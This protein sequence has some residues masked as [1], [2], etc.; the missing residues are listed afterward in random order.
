MSETLLR[1]QELA[2]E[3]RRGGSTVRAV[4][5]IDF[6][7]A[8]G[9]TL[10]LVGESGCGKSTVAKSV[11]R[12]LRPTRGRIEFD[13]H[14]L[15]PLSERQLR[16]HRPRLQMVFQDPQASLNPRMTVRDAIIEPLIIHR[17][18]DRTAR[19]ARVREM[20][21]RVG[22]ARRME[23]RFPFQ[24]SGGQQQRVALARALALNPDLVVADE[25]TSAL[26]V[27]IQ[28]QI[29]E[30]L[31]ELQRDLGIAYLLISHNL[32]AVRQLAHQ[33][34]VMYLGRVCEVGPVRDVLDAPR[35]PYT[36][37]L[38]SAAPVPDPEV[39]AT[40]ERIVLVG[41]VP[42]PTAPPSGCRFHTRCWLRTQLGNP[43]VCTTTDPAAQERSGGGLVHCH[44]TEQMNLPVAAVVP[45]RHPV[46]GETT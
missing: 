12:L 21:D 6:E 42:S 29:L 28:A 25:P 16:P 13:G 31:A 9:Q 4:D 44:F 37:A 11:V 17:R 1:V 7:L 43:D 40:R 32:G 34:V 30:L 33:V 10:A 23:Q 36:E 19:E 35:H 22:L 24:L 5:G 14:D 3:Y 15:V 20:M 39:E 27:S 41:D 2:V 8:G 46:E 45:E 38:R 26:D 18:G